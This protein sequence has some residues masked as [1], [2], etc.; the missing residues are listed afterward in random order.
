MQKLSNLPKYKY[1][2]VVELRF[3]LDPRVYTL[4]HHTGLPLHSL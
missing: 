2:H 1:Q 3:E 4:K